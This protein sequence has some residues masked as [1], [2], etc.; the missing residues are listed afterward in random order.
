MKRL[1]AGNVEKWLER[2]EHGLKKQNITSS[3]IM[4]NVLTRKW[5]WREKIN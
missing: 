3:I 4:I 5:D 2:I 1:N